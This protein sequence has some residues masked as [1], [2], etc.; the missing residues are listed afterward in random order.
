MRNKI[1]TLEAEISAIK[2]EISR[3]Q[4]QEQ[5]L[6]KDLPV[7]IYQGDP[8]RFSVDTKVASEKLS[9][10]EPKLGWIADA[11]AALE[12]QLPAKIAALIEL[13]K[14]EEDQARR[15]RLED[16]K[17]RLR[18]KA[19]DVETA[20]ALL[21][22]LYLEF[23][24][25]HSECSGDFRS[26]Y[27]IAGSYL[28]WDSLLGFQNLCI[29]KLVESHGRFT[30]IGENFDVFAAEKRAA[31][32]KERQAYATRLVEAER[33]RNEADRRRKNGIIQQ[34]VDQLSGELSM[35]QKELKSAEE[36]RAEW[37]KYKSSESDINRANHFISG[38]SFEV[39]EL[40]AKISKLQDSIAE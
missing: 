11:I 13:K 8:A 23:K 28:P 3:L 5:Q 30:L 38:L 17:T 27:Y 37:V 36:T 29:P 21:E 9:I 2:S 31:D 35:K 7:A 16:G 32:L 19:K 12:G 33:V 40:E 4:Q 6:K 18:A 34:E 15:Q 39:K 20:A 26:E 22:S 10:Q 24:S 25:I 1:I 14:Q